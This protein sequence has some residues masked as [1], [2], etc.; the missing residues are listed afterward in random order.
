MKKLIMM[1]AVA[2]GLTG[3]AAQNDRLISF[4][5]EGPDTYEDGTAILDGERCALVWVKTGSVFGGF[6]VQ[7]PDEYRVLEYAACALNGHFEPH[8]FRVAHELDLQLDP[9]GDYQVFVLDTRNGKDTLSELGDGGVPARINDFK[10]GLGKTQEQVEEFENFLLPGPDRYSD[11]MLVREGEIYAL[12]WMKAGTAFKGFRNSPDVNVPVVRCVDEANNWFYRV[13]GRA[14]AQG[15]CVKDD[16]VTLEVPQ[17][18]ENGH[19]AIFLMDTRKPGTNELTDRDDGRPV[20][21]QGYCEVQHNTAAATSGWTPVKVSEAGKAFPF[22]PSLALADGFAAVYSY[23]S[24]K[25]VWTVR[26]MPKAWAELQESNTVF[27]TENDLCVLRAPAKPLVFPCT[28]EVDY[29]FNVAESNDMRR[30]I[31]KIVSTKGLMQALLTMKSEADLVPYLDVLDAQDIELLKGGALADWAAKV[32]PFFQWNADFAV[33]FDR[34]VTNGTVFLDGQYDGAAKWGFDTWVGSAFANDLAAGEEI[35][36]LKQGYQEVYLNYSE[37]CT[38]VIQF[39]CGAMNLSSNNWGTTMTVKLR[40]YENTG[41]CNETK[42]SFTVDTYKYTFKGPLNVRFYS[43]DVEFAELAIATNHDGRSE[44]PLP[45]YHADSDVLAFTGWSNAVDNTIW[46]SVPVRTWADADHPISLYATFKPAQTVQIAPTSGAAKVAFKVTDEWLES[47]KID[48]TSSASM[49]SNLEERV[50]SKSDL[51]YWQTYL[52]GIK[53]DADAELK[54]EKTNGDED[55]KALVVSTVQVVAPDAGFKVAY[56]LDK[57]DADEK[58]VA[59]K[60]DEQE[61]KDLKIDLE[62]KDDTPTGYYKMN[63]IF[64]PTEDGVEKT[65]EKVSIPADNTIGVLKVESTEPVVPV[66]V[67]WKSLENY[68]RGVSVDELVKTSTLTEGDKMHVYDKEANAYRNYQLAGGTWQHV[69]SFVI[70]DKGVVTE[71]PAADPTDETVA[72]GSGVWLERQNPEKPFYLIGQYKD[73]DQAFST[74]DAPTEDS[75]RGV[76]YNLIA[77]TGISDTDLNEVLPATA[78]KQVNAED[79]IVVVRDGAPVRYRPTSDGKWGYK[80]QVYEL[81]NGRV[82]ITTIDETNDAKVQAGLGMWYISAGGKP[83]IEWPK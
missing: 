45:A 65:K 75:T 27:E 30:L 24:G 23:E 51:T 38:N 55:D 15:K 18:Y 68:E 21:L 53:P 71:T 64:T 16:G 79:M 60:G 58:T 29:V 74:V 28:N 82:R 2:V 69:N 31:A 39:K 62:P 37:I 41:R 72:R 11:G 4:Y 26:E 46:G 77:P 9:A 57:V 25:D 36:L 17:G 14:D 12:V 32:M 33:S 83:K 47:N 56:S 61:T 22:D 48:R 76:E 20:F 66:A 10:S 78:E 34:G 19:F 80:K 49:S 59:K 52:L 1:M 63:V 5:T 73:N 67:P 8:V 7:N 35:R 40:L 42:S 70:D 6:E 13:Y 43:N 81:R 50:N 3:F 54:V 44:F